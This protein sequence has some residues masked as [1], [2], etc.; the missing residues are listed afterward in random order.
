MDGM[1]GRAQ[2][3]CA[4]TPSLTPPLTLNPTP[5][6]TPTPTLGMAVLRSVWLIFSIVRTLRYGHG[7]MLIQEGHTFKML[8]TYT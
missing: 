5:T 6:S 2:T 7:M 3:R 8:Q 1:D 4:I